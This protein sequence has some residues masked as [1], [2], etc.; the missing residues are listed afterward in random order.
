M[1]CIRCLKK[2]P[3]IRFERE[4]NICNESLCL[5]CL[6]HYLDNLKDSKGNITIYNVNKIIPIYIIKPKKS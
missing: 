2:P 4:N 5:D 3:I 1:I 6:I